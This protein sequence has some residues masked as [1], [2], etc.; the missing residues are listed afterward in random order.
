MKDFFLSYAIP[1]MQK[2]REL[3]GF[4]TALNTEVAFDEYDIQAGDNWL[5]ATQNLLENSKVC[6]VM[7]SNNSKRASVQPREVYLAQ[8]LQNRDPNWYR[9]VPVYLND[10]AGAPPIEGLDTVSAYYERDGGLRTVAT[11]LKAAL[12]RIGDRADMIVRSTTALDE[13][14]RIWLNEG[15]RFGGRFRLDGDDVVLRMPGYEFTRIRREEFEAKLSSAEQRQ[16]DQIE[17]KMEAL[18]QAWQ[19]NDLQVESSTA[20]EKA[21]EFAAKLGSV[22][23]DLLE[24]LMNG[25]FQLEDHYEHIRSTVASYERRQGAS[26]NG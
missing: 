26:S 12:A 20:Q 24:L 23:K 7:L 5:R 4:L 16:V 15:K 3:A 25:G 17:S 1:D 6:V 19:K 10:H 13:I 9:L 22:V 8:Y 21:D 11:K 14:A 18:Y 2:A